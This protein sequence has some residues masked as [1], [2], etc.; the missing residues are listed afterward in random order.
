LQDD[1]GYAYTAL[2]SCACACQQ[3]LPPHCSHA[4]SKNT[5]KA[6]GSGR[7]ECKA[8]VTHLL[9]NAD[10]ITLMLLQALF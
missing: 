7:V 4:K 1:S 8:F 6:W 9:V 3:V 10:G 2:C 5:S